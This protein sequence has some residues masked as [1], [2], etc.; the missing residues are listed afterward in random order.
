MRTA[1]IKN[2]L[3][4]GINS[5]AFP[6][7]ELLVAR[8]GKIVCHLRVGKNPGR[9]FDLASLTKPLC[10]AFL[11]M[12]ATEEGRLNPEMR[13]ADFIKAPNLVRVTIGQL[14]K[15]ASGLIDWH[16]FA[17]DKRVIKKPNPRHKIFSLISSDKKLRHKKT[18][19]VYSDLGYILLGEILEKAYGQALE[20]VFAKCVTRPLKFM[21]RSFFRNCVIKSLSIRA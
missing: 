4:Q 20:R 12:L 2:L 17:R 14:L 13:A 5:G 9:L 3:Q 6:S 21:T 7:A 16:D 19:T 18:R 15:H 10:T 1:E 11:A 8:H